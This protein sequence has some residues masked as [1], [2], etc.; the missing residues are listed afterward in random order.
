MNPSL[1]CNAEPATPYFINFLP[2]IHESAESNRYDVGSPGVD[3]WGKPRQDYV[4]IN[5]D[6]ANG[7]GVT[8]LI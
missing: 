3:F 1:M 8:S 4:K 2:W 6:W 7:I 5:E